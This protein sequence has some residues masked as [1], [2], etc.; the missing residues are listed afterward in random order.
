M[1]DLYG[2]KAKVIKITDGDTID[3]EIDCGYSI[4]TKQRCRLYGVNTPETRTRDP[5]E[6]ELGLKAKKYV[7]TA[8]KCK[9]LRIKSEQ[10]IK[11]GEEKKGKYGRYLV[12]VWYSEDGERWK[13]LNHELVILGLATCYFG[14]AR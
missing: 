3:F 9:H 13:N 5:I 2:Y 7:K 10:K 11:T 14:G 4:F 12:A 6:K 8:L 1:I